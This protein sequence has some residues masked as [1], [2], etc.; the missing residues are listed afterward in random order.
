MKLLLVG[1]VHFRDDRPRCRTEEDF[2]QTQLD[3][4]A[5]LLSIAVEKEV[6]A[7]LQAGDFFHRWNPSLE[8]CSQLIEV[9][10]NA[11]E[12]AQIPII[13][14]YGQHDL[15]HHSFSEV[16]KSGRW[17]LERAG[18]FCSPAECGLGGVGVFGWGIPLAE[19][20]PVVII[21]KMV[22]QAGR[23]PFPDAVGVTAEELFE[24]Y[25]QV[26]L[27][28]TGDN[29][30]YFAATGPQHQQLFNPGCLIRE[31]VDEKD[32]PCAVI[33][34]DTENA[35]AEEHIPIGVVRGHVGDTGE[36]SGPDPDGL[37]AFVEQAASHSSEVG[38]DYRRNVEEFMNQNKTAPQVQEEVVG[39]MEDTGNG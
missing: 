23:P 11:P 38:L 13:G 39:A 28:V 32:A 19:P 20:P 5:A 24:T 33:Y 35:M 27:W 8:L 36:V 1:D 26:K 3:K 16:E 25:P 14:C 10:Q 29:H 12:A 6:D 37:G 7:V 2:R 30:R 15:P 21:H 34:V 9:W 18:V 17:L 31:H 4:W 22:F